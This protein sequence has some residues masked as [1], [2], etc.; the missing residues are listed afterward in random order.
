MEGQDA[1]AFITEVNDM[2]SCKP[3][4]QLCEDAIR[5]MKNKFPNNCFKE[6]SCPLMHN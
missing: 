3:E 4:G 1:M 5:N 6:K 2:L